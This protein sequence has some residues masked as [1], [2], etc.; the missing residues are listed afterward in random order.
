MKGIQEA[1]YK[2]NKDRKNLLKEEDIAAA[3]ANRNFLRLT[4]TPYKFHLIDSSW[5]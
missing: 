3:L 2:E 4:H 5:P 1:L